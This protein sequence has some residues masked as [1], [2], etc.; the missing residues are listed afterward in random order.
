MIYNNKKSSLSC[1]CLIVISTAA[2][3][4]Q[5]IHGVI[6]KHE[7]QDLELFSAFNGE[8]E[9]LFAKLDQTTTDVGKNALKRILTEPL[10][11]I[12]ALE[13]RQSCIKELCSDKILFEINKDL[14]QF[15]KNERNLQDFFT[16]KNNIEQTIIDSFYFKNK[17][18]L[19]Y[20]ESAYCLDIGQVANFTSLIAP[21]LEHIVF[22]C[23]LSKAAKER[24]NIKGCC[25][26]H[27][28]GHD[29]NEHDHHQ[30]SHSHD[31]NYL[32]KGKDFLLNLVAKTYSNWGFHLH[33]L[34]HAWGAK[35]IYEDLTQ[36]SKIIKGIQGK[37]I[38]LRKSIDSFKNL[39]NFL[40]EN[41]A[42][43]NY[44]EKDI[45]K[46]K[47]FADSTSRSAQFQK[48][49]NLLSS[50][51]FQGEPS[52]LSHTGAILAAYY[53]IGQVKDEF[54]QAINAIGEIDAFASIAKLYLAHSGSEATFSFA[55]L[56]QANKPI[57]GINGFWNPFI[58]KNTVSCNSITLGDKEPQIALITGP[59]AGGKSTTL[60][61]LTIA[62]LLAQ[63]FTI[64]PAQSVILTP[65]DKIITSFNVIDSINNGKSLFMGEIIR[66]NLILKDLKNRKPESFSFIAIDEIFRSTS[67]EKGQKAAYNFIEE[68]GKHKNN[69][70]IISSHFPALI[71][72]ESIEP[73]T[74]KNY[75][76]EVTRNANSKQYLLKAGASDQQQAF[77]VLKQDDNQ[78]LYDMDFLVKISEKD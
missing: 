15:A 75:S 41:D 9:G 14:E 57:V 26:H 52:C 47:V 37:I 11:D 77:E 13:N 2:F 31:K 34:V 18:L 73:Q 5:A 72:L 25:H 74:F 29:A 43:K 49:L 45:L 38:G 39:Y 65:F 51:T 46:L 1:K 19:K 78:D 32:S 55:K 30:C 69:V 36:K 22:G 6:G 48:L 35:A 33:M 16:S 63:T 40:S 3:L 21:Y 59:H 4:N 60:K 53:L 17:R 24:L 58:N 76:V 42:L 62:I 44:F 70:S 54:T 64:V 8:G 7:E 50:N 28:H 66:A 20:N 61:A 27:E 68:I 10:S 56:V 23:L 71:K 12:K 67:F